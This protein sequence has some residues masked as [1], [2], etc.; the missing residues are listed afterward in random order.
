MPDDRSV[1][2]PARAD[3]DGLCPSSAAAVADDEGAADEG[4]GF[5]VADAYGI[6]SSYIEVSASC[7]IL[8]LESSGLVWTEAST[9]AGGSGCPGHP[10]G[11]LTTL[12]RLVGSI[13][14][15]SGGPY[16]R[17]RALPSRMLIAIFLSL[18]A[19]MILVFPGQ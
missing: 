10:I 9:T 11:L 6:G 2:I 13:T 14:L 17:F 3:V 8:L 5:G 12:G 7:V 1:S 16:P 18:D 4:I 19:M 15:F